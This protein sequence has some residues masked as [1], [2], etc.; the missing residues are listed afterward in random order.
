MSPIY[1][2]VFWNP[3]KG[4]QYTFKHRKP[5]APKAAKVYEAHGASF[6]PRTACELESS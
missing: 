1:D 5:K 3:P 2:A 4:E 6:S